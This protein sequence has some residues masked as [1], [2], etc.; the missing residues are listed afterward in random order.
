MYRRF[1]MVEATH[2]SRWMADFYRCPE[3]RIMFAGVNSSFQNPPVFLGPTSAERTSG[4]K[5]VSRLRYCW[6]HLFRRNKKPV[7]ATKRLITRFVTSN[8]SPSYIRSV[9]DAFRR[10]RTTAKRILAVTAISVSGC[11]D[12]VAPRGKVFRCERKIQWP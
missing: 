4:D 1:R 11:S 10:E 12:S 3:C 6:D 2:C 5:H 7:H 8:P 9:V